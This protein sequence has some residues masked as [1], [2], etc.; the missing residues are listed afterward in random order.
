MPP[1]PP[2][3]VA[4]DFLRQPLHDGLLDWT[5]ANQARFTP[6]PVYRAAGQEVASDTRSN[7]RLRDLGPLEEELTAALLAALPDIARGLG[8]AMPDRPSLELE[9]SAYGDGDF[10]HAHLDTVAGARA[11]AAGPARTISAV[12]YFHRQPKGFDGG[13]LRLL[14]WEGEAGAR[15]IAPDDNR[16]AA[17][18]SWSR[19]EV[20]PVRCPSGDFADSRFAINCWYCEG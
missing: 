13:A 11:A 16:L 14:P 1:I 9:L 12:Y 18:L 6:A 20:L 5:L 3:H 10:Y 7:L 19:H 15:D 4:D 8:C 2:C 17:F